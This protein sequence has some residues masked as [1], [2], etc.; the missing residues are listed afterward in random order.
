AIRPSLF[1]GNRE[2]GIERLGLDPAR[3]IVLVIGGS[4]GALELNHLVREALHL[5]CP[6]VQVVHQTGKAHFKEAIASIPPDP[7]VRASY[8]PL[9]YIGPEIADLYAAA[10]VVAGRAGAGTVWEA[11]S[12]EKPMVLI[13][14][15]GSGTRGDQVENARLAEKAGAAR[16]LLGKDVN[17]RAFAAAILW[18]LEPEHGK[19]A[20]AACRDL[21]QIAKNTLNS[22]DYIARLILDRIGWRAKDVS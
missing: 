2:R 21:T 14:L 19:A 6:H 17:A 20:A 1:E 22:S 18:F 4:Q 11:A 12:L 16:V 10:D 15:A 7:R 9:D 13:P 8:R 5:L 3:P